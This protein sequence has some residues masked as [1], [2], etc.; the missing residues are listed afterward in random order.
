VLATCV[1]A[2][3]MA[4]SMQPASGASSSV[5]VTLD[6]ISSTSLVTT[7]CA[8][9]TAGRTDF[10][11]VQPG[12]TVLTS[13][14]C[15]LTFGSSNDTGRLLVFQRDGLGDALARATDGTP[16]AGW[17]AGGVL[18]VATAPP[19]NAQ[20]GR[21]FGL[22]R[23]TDGKLVLSGSTDALG[24]AYITRVSPTTGA[25]DTS[26][27]DGDGDGVNGVGIIDYGVDITTA[28]AAVTDSRDRL[29]VIGIYGISG[30]D[31]AFIARYTAE[32]E[33]DNSWSG[34]GVAWFQF[35]GASTDD[36]SKYVQLDSQERAVVV[37]RTRVG[38]VD[39]AGV[40]R[41]TV[42]G[43]LDTTFSGDGR[44]SQDVLG[45]GGTVDSFDALAIRADDSFVAAGHGLVA[46]DG[47]DEQGIAV[48]FAED[49][50]ASWTQKYDLGSATDRISHVAFDAAGRTYL[51]GR[52]RESAGNDDMVVARVDTAT[53]VLDTATYGG[54][55]GIA[56]FDNANAI[57]NGTSMYVHADG[58]AMVV[59]QTLDGGDNDGFVGRARADG[60]PDTT[61]SGDGELVIDQVAGSADLAEF[62][63]PG[64]DGGMLALG[65]SGAN[66]TFLTRL[67]GVAIADFVF[68]SNDF[69]QGTS[70]AFGMCIHDA[71]ATTTPTAPWT[72]AGTGNCTATLESN[73][74][75]IPDSSADAAAQVAAADP[76]VAAAT[77][78]F[79]FGVRTEIGTSKGTYEAPI[80]F[81]V[82]AP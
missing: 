75:G 32:G 79:R 22:A 62:V 24:N 12:S 82:L 9:S 38:G 44:W 37:G 19:E 35:D 50:T 1:L 41:F 28:Y 54:G 74:R 33:V 56:S 8:T 43:E 70:G 29:Y 15:A 13:Q 42:D 48:R 81:Q 14:D 58:R 27:A 31:D 23:Q 64:T 40:A 18:E 5:V 78:G 73:W 71:G 80:T 49:G 7:G 69:N 61:F 65:R 11:T 10:G 16:Q 72:E 55:N 34:D 3:A 59:G 57:D 17:G 51:S 63:L 68:N 77:I 52:G 39:R 67:S 30:T 2:A 4:V 45:G 6:V 66:R 46:A 60:T 36:N 47:A 21:A 20:V 53:G 26:F 25:V 76:N